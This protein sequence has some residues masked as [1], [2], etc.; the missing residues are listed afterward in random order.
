MRKVKSSIVERNKQG[1]WWN[2]PV[3]LVHGIAAGS[4]LGA[5]ILTSH[6][7]SDH[8]VYGIIVLG[9]MLIQLVGVRHQY[10]PSPTLWLVTV[11]AVVLNLS[12]WI[13][14]DGSFHLVSNLIAMLL[15]ILYVATV[16]FESMQRI[17]LSSENLLSNVKCN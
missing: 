2:A 6:G 16:L 17:S 8:T 13:M 15:A 14:P 1:V 12:G 4:L 9:A 10:T 5:T 3:R 11:V 7:N